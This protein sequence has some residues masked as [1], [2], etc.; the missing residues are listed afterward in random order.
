MVWVGEGELR[1]KESEKYID[2][3]LTTERHKDKGKKKERV[4]NLTMK[5]LEPNNNRNCL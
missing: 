4:L 2:I 5:S 1:K 3:F